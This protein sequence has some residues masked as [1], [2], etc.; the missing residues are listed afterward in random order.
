MML[1]LYEDSV[2]ISVNKMFLLVKFRRVSYEIT[3][4]REPGA[5]NACRTT[6]SSV[7]G[8]A[9]MSEQGHPVQSAQNK[10]FSTP[11]NSADLPR[12]F[13]YWESCSA[14]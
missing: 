4:E 5:A 14:D 10:P 8:K 6:G 3:P 9:R 2:A 1:V 13:Q 11:W 7:T 12:V